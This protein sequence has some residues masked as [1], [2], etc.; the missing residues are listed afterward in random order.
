MAAE[1]GRRH[2]RCMVLSGDFISRLIEANLS[3]IGESKGLITT[4]YHHIDSFTGDTSFLLFF[5]KSLLAKLNDIT[6]HSGS[7][8][9]I[10][11]WACG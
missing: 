7:L 4:G 3:S 10:W 6:P 9:I 2:F 1:R 5:G 11:L 8:K